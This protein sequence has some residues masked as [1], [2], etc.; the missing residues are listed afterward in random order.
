MGSKVRVPG[1][2]EEGYASSL[3]FL[4]LPLTRAPGLRPLVDQEHVKSSFLFSLASLTALSFIS[5][6]RIQVYMNRARESTYIYP[7]TL[8]T[9]YS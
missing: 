2:G 7:T 1:K 9:S 4:V 5:R 3:P 8:V 6:V